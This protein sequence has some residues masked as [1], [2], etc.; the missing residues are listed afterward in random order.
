MMTLIYALLL[1]AT[2][3]LALPI[4]LLLLQIL[5]AG[6]KGG[7]LSPPPALEV[8]AQIAVLV[9]AHDEARNIDSTVRGV[10]QEVR[11]GDRVLVVAD[12]CSDNTAALA[13]AAGAEVVERQDALRRGKGY[14]LDFG[15]KHLAAT[16]P[17][18]VVIVDADCRVGRGAMTCLSAAA[19]QAGAPAQA[20]YR[21]ALAPGA[22][23]KIKIAGLAWR[24]KNLVRPLGYRHMGLPCQ[25][26]GS[27]MA[28]P[29]ALIHR[30]DLASGHLV[31]DLKLGLDL[32]QMRVSP[33]FVPQ[34]EVVSAFPESAAG[35]TTQRRRWE[36]GHLGMV[37]VAPKLLWRGLRSANLGLFALAADL[38]IPPL[39]LL[40]L[41]TLTVAA[42]SSL[43]GWFL[44]WTAPA[45]MAW[46]LCAGLWL[47]IFTAWFRHGRDLLTFRELAGVPIYI[48]WK[49]PI[50]L[51]FLLRRERNWVRSAREGE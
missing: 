38:C 26:M 9:P 32:A 39:A 14:A 4:G 47:A 25:L 15:L 33:V 16:P 20:H 18:V 22:G 19:L 49:V 42:L 10:L 44:H 17:D 37:S 7:R 31:E 2:L 3:A 50:Y 43:A 8:D 24:V 13:R 48:L 12:N 27:G 45:V 1:L 29:W 21:M 28:F 11:V 5:S 51:S 30:V 40:T 34:A 36:H 46:A 23:L 41:L 35:V 6:F